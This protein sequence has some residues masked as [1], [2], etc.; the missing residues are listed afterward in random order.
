MKEHSFSGQHPE[1][2]AEIITSI[3]WG[4]D[5]FQIWHLSKNLRL[6]ATP[7]YFIARIKWDNLPPFHMALCSKITSYRD[8]SDNRWHYTTL[9]LSNTLQRR[10][11][12]HSTGRFEASVDR[13]QAMPLQLSGSAVN[14]N[15]TSTWTVSG[16]HSVPPANSLGRG[17]TDRTPA[18]KH[19]PS[20]GRI[21]LLKCLLYGTTSETVLATM[22]ATRNII[23][24]VSYLVFLSSWVLTL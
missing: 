1:I 20:T 4:F 6:W 8:Q 5:H 22:A 9:Y 19:H 11:G 2:L 10:L 18:I 16:Y 15:S 12:S 21:K 17:Q 13:F 23:Y 24:R 14:L 3:F 7:S